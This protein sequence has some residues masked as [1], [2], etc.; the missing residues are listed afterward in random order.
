MEKTGKI[1]PN[2][3]LQI[4]RSRYAYTTARIRAMEN[5]LINASRLSRYFETRN[6]EELSRL[7]IEDGYPAAADPEDSLQLGLETAFV[8]M[9]ELSPDPAL[10]DT[11]LLSRDIHNL[12]VMLKSFAVYWPRRQPEQKN[13]E[14][15]TLGYSEQTAGTEPASADA[16]QMST[17][18]PEIHAPVSLEQLQPLLQKPS[19]IAP[20]VLFKALR[21]RK[22]NELPPEIVE[23][24]AEA[25][26]RYLRSYDVSEIDIYL[27]QT[28]AR[29]FSR[30]A[31][32]VENDFFRDFI[33]LRI[34]LINVGM[35]LR[36]RFLKSGADYLARVLL[37]GGQIPAEKLLEYYDEPIEEIV[38]VLS[39][40]RLAGLAGSVEHF[41]RGGEAIA[42]FSQAQDE[43]LMRFVQ[44]AKRV[45]R[46]PEAIIGYLIAREME[47]R[48][49]RIILTC[50]RNNIPMEKARELARLTYL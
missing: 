13:R 32:G 11:L 37:P 3:Q 45:L 5:G 28:Q 17:L 31:A 19:T 49:I 21:S 14:A 29:M 34:D 50:L 44:N 36:T 16:E 6:A 30:A 33:S 25:S 12:K 27:D 10:I 43:I 7:L 15:A 39:T 8:E 4:D 47:I 35:L 9:R 2:K 18:W 24:A 22:T 46:G 20:E 1:K 38:S 23:A 42:R 26:A 48:T 40:T 41:A